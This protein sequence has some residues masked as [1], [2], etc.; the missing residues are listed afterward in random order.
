VYNIQ[1][2]HFG[3]TV[4]CEGSLSLDMIKRISKR[5]SLISLDLSVSGLYEFH[6]E[7]YHIIND[8]EEVKDLTIRFPSGSVENNILMDSFLL[9]FSR[10]SKS[11]KLS[12]AGNITPEA[13]HRVYK[14]MTEGSSK[15]RSLTCDQTK[16]GT[17]FLFLRFI[18]II[19][20]NGLPCSTNSIEVYRRSTDTVDYWIFDGPVEFQIV[21]YVTSDGE[22]QESLTIEDFGDMSVMSHDDQ[23]SL[24]EAK[25]R[26][27]K[28]GRRINAI[29]L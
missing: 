5:A 14:N 21:L 19:F 13:L 8:L 28:E 27:K 2:T 1:L 17:I 16:T 9:N 29:R 23:K 12:R 15:L 7:M 10:Y 4:R 22:D 26:A 20:R 3:S 25:E 6:R 24:M 11:F 18:G